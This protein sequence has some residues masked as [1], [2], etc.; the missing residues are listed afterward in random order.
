MTIV[1]TTMQKVLLLLSLVLALAF[2]QECD[3]RT[4]GQLLSKKAVV[5]SCSG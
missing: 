1:N 3:T 5:Q 2:A 4:R